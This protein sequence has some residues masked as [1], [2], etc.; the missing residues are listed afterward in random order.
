MSPMSSRTTSID[1]RRR[2]QLT[3]AAGFTIL[4][5][6][7]I[8]W[9]TAQRLQRGVAHGTTAASATSSKPVPPL[10][11][12]MPESAKR[13][14]A[15]T[16]GVDQMSARLV[17]S[18]ALV[19]FD[20]RVIDVAKAAPLHDRAAQPQ[21]LDAKARAVLQ[22]PVMEKIGPLRQSTAPKAGKSYWMT[23]SNKGNLVKSGHRVS[24][25]IGPFR[26]DGLV[27]E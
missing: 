11:G 1:S 10:I 4:A 20:Y 13:Y 14:Y 27:V 23:F 26:V 7:L 3:L 8:A 18:G 9:Q 17:E 21:M 16:W 24:V 12:R 22:I 19:R 6:A 5:V 25:E 2:L 15:L